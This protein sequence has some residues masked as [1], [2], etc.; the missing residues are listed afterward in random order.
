M[1]GDIKTTHETH[2]E[3]IGITEDYE[4]VYL[5]SY[6]IH[7]YDGQDEGRKHNA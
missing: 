3:L 2:N 1:E 5:K 4:C 7:V 6:I